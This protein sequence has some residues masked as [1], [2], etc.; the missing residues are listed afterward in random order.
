LKNKQVRKEGLN[1]RIEDNL[2]VMRRIEQ[3]WNERDWEIFERLQ[4]ED[5]FVV[6]AVAVGIP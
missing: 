2:E 4:A 3:A 6:F 5:V 1:R